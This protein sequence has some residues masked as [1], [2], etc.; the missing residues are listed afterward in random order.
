M[1]SSARSVVAVRHGSEIGRQ[2]RQWPRTGLALSS[3]PERMDIRKAAQLDEWGHGTLSRM[4][5][6]DREPTATSRSARLDYMEDATARAKIHNSRSMTTFKKR[7]RRLITD[8]FK[9]HAI[10]IGR[11]WPVASYKARES[12]SKSLRNQMSKT[13]IA[14]YQK[15]AEKKRITQRL[16]DLFLN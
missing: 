13:N 12:Q 16:L 3:K 11:S 1:S 6:G 7:N 15:I 8:P 4:K 10:P 14:L 5:A 9:P 2:L